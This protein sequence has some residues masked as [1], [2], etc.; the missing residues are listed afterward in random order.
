[1]PWNQADADE[2]GVRQEPTDE[3]KASG[4]TLFEEGYGVEVSK[5]KA[6][7]LY[8]KYKPT[9]KVEEK[10]KTHLEKYIEERN[11]ITREIFKKYPCKEYDYLCEYDKEYAKLIFD[12]CITWNEDS[13][14]LQLK[15]RDY[16][17]SI[18]LTM[19]DIYG[20]AGIIVE[21]NIKDLVAS[22]EKE[23]KR[24][25]DPDWGKFGLFE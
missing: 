20:K 18:G 15:R 6:N 14:E 11:K 8:A 21:S 5:N 25:Q 4:K 9:P 13:I 2:N 23:I 10:Q 16:L 17:L 19:Y 22:K 1:M 12:K 7:E 3:Q 24:K